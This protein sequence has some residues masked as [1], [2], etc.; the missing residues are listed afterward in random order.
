[1][2]TNHIDKNLNL[3]IF[4]STRRPIFPLLLKFT[5]KSIEKRYFPNDSEKYSFSQIKKKSWWKI[6]RHIK[7]WNLIFA[8]FDSLFI[9]YFFFFIYYFHQGEIKK[10]TSFNS[11]NIFDSLSR[12]YFLSY[13]HQGE[14]TLSKKVGCLKKLALTLS[15]STY[16]LL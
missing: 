10:N 6:W 8:L 2:S 1:M 4:F 14:I 9:N 3:A 13:F 11:F 16:I 5:L 7:I 15:I 12:N